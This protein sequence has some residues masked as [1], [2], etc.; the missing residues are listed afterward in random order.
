MFNK[1]TNRLI[2]GFSLPLVFLILLGSFLIASDV[3][4]IRLQEESK[5]TSE[6][7]KNTNE[8][9]YDIARIVACTRGYVL[10]TK[11]QYYRGVCDASRKAMLVNRDELKSI[12][13][14]QVREAV[15]VI[16]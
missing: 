12:A 1:I 11:D 7:I 16:I 9:S 15:N 13:D 5:E 3:N 10:W 2:L 8:I 4:L 14:P 6:T